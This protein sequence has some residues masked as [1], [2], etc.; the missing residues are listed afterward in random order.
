MAQMIDQVR[1][2]RFIT[3]KRKQKGLT[4]ADIA[5]RL[6]I[7]DRAV[8][9]WERGLCLPDAAQVIP[10]CSILGITVDELLSGQD[11]G[12]SEARKSAESLL[13]EMKDKE[14][15][16]NSYLLRLEWIIGIL[17]II[18]GLVILFMALCIVSD[19]SVP[20]TIMLVIISSAIFVAGIYHA[21]KIERNA[22]YYECRSCNHR[23]V[24]DMASVMMAPH[25][26]R[27]RYMKCPSCGKRTWQRKV[28]SR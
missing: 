2:G 19:V 10:L 13:L 14:E 8:S 11:I 27:T 23:Y 22:G 25:M 12:E 9:K 1:T 28:L 4:Q 5:E 24:P 21:L 16:T 18:P 17:F 15:E 26:G 7:T 20:L 3:E 6:G